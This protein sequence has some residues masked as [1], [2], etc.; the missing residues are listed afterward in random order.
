MAGSQKESRQA[1]HFQG[2]RQ[3]LPKESS[4]HF[5]TL[6]SGRHRSRQ[7]AKL[8]ARIRPRRQKSHC[9]KTFRP[10]T[11]YLRRRRRRFQNS[12]AHGESRIAPLSDQ[13]GQCAHLRR[14][15]ETRALLYQKS[16][17]RLFF[18]HSYSL[19]FRNAAERTSLIESHRRFLAGNRNE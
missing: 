15:G 19:V 11:L 1:F 16:E 6:L 5:R 9:G 4:S 2:I 18:R 8:S 10:L 3:T 14:R 7:T 17:Q 13:E 12:V